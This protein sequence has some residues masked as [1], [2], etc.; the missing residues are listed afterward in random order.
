MHVRRTGA[1]PYLLGL[2]LCE[3]ISLPTERKVCRGSK[4]FTLLHRSAGVRKM[5]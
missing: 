4:E 1:D 3:V 5:G 2:D